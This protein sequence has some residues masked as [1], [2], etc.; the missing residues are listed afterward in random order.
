MRVGRSSRTVLTGSPSVPLGSCFERAEGVD[1]E[2]DA[3]LVYSKT[4]VMSAGK[5]TFPGARLSA[6]TVVGLTMDSW[7]A[8]FFFHRL[9]G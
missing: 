3:T 6:R 2:G 7:R 1:G 4:L 5:E 9:S 8:Y